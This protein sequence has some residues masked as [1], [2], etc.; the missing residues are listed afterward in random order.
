MRSAKQMT[1]KNYASK[2]EQETSNPLFYGLRKQTLAFILCLLSHNEI[3][4]GFLHNAFHRV[5]RSAGGG[6]FNVKKLMKTS[7]LMATENS[8]FERRNVAQVL[9]F[10]E[11]QTDVTVILIGTMH[12]NPASISM[13]RDTLENLANEEK[14]GSVIIES[15]DIRW[16]ESKSAGEA[17]A[18]KN[19]T[20]KFLQNEMRVAHDTAITYGRPVVLGDQRINITTSSIAQTAR[21]TLSDIVTP[22]SG[23]WERFYDEMKESFPENCPTGV[24]DD[25]YRYIDSSGILDMRLLLSLPSTLVKYPLSWFVRFPAGGLVFVSILL[26]L[27]RFS[28]MTAVP[29][30]ASVTETLGDLS[31]S[32]LFAAFEVALFGRIFLRS[33]LAERNKIIGKNILEQCKIYTSPTQ[34]STNIFMAL[35]EGLGMWNNLPDPSIDQQSAASLKFDVTYAPDSKIPS[36]F[37]EKEKTVVAVLGMAH[38]NG[39]MKLL[40]EQN[41]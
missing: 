3:S 21:E 30:D 26:G 6:N 41:V 1:C 2:K 11:P 5:T 27:N 24:D 38:C 34:K 16:N 4:E 35:K 39:V 14:L 9:E 23:G 28:D 15:C 22:F 19:L 25:G 29:P 32:I 33:L 37:F 13:V 36:M 8:V 18:A 7:S 10:K 20:K 31:A 12:Y 17:S 40:K